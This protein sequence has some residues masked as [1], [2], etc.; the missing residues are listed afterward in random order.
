MSKWTLNGSSWRTTLLFSGGDDGEENDS[1][2]ILGEGKLELDIGEL[3]YNNAPDSCIASLEAVC[4]K[5]VH[6]Y[7]CDNVAEIES[8]LRDSAAMGH[9]RCH[10]ALRVV[11][12]AR[13]R[14]IGLLQMGDYGYAMLAVSPAM[15]KK[16]YRLF[17]SAL[18]SGKDGQFRYSLVGEF[19]LGIDKIHD[20]RPTAEQL[21]SGAPLLSNWIKIWI[22]T[23]SEPE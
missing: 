20:H 8:S 17:E 4:D 7:I 19:D 2:E 10:A 18:V 13:G 14:S 1:V 9:E 15:F 3:R 6:W 23:R 11:E 5:H 16:V 22:D 21:A 12:S